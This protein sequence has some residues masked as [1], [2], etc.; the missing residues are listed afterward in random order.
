M[1]QKTINNSPGRLALPSV[2]SD[3][4]INSIFLLQLSQ[5]LEYLLVLWRTFL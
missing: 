5:W 2:S 3:L 4:A 1:L